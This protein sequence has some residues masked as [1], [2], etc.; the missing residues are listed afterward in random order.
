MNDL[1]SGVH[2]LWK[3]AMIDWMAPQPNQTLV[4]LAGG[5]GDIVASCVRAAE[6]R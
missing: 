3:T 5:A 2:R 1:M 4:D 6:T